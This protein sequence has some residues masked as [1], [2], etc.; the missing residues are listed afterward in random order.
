VFPGFDG[1]CEG[2]QWRLAGKRAIRKTSRLILLGSLKA[3]D[4]EPVLREVEAFQLTKRRI[5]P[6]DFGGTL[7]NAERSWPLLQQLSPDI[8]C[9]SEALERLDVGPSEQ[10]LKE[11]R[12]GFQI[13]RQQQKRLRWFAGAAFAFA[14]IAIVAGWQWYEAVRQRNLAISREL[15]VSA[16]SQLGVDPALSVLLAAE[17]MRMARTVEADFALRQALLNSH[18]RVVMRAYGEDA[19][20]SGAFGSA[21]FSP[22]GNRVVAASEDGTAKVWD[23]ETGEKLAEL[24]EHAGPIRSAAFSPNGEADRNGQRRQD[25]EGVGRRDRGEAR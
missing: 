19:V 23:A 20:E 16:N 13:T 7:R 11:I 25:G 8:L 3:L 21:A 1:V 18:V 24:A 12:D 9:I 22:N 4:S 17:A 10:A 14:V 6:I 5:V 2:R 15:A